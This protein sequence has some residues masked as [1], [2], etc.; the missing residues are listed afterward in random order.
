MFAQFHAGE[1]CR[2]VSAAWRPQASP[3]RL[4]LA[5]L[6]LHGQLHTGEPTVPGS[7]PK[8]HL[9]VVH[10]APQAAASFLSSWHCTPSVS[11]LHVCSASYWWVAEKPLHNQ[12]FSTLSREVFTQNASHSTTARLVTSVVHKVLARPSPPLALG[13]PTCEAPCAPRRAKQQPLTT[14]GSTPPNLSV[15]ESVAPTAS[16][17]H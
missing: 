9:P 14:C 7:P 4:P 1:H 8:R 10:S 13:G 5:S 2:G 3:T 15:P 11:L 17:P 16:S 12:E 6:S